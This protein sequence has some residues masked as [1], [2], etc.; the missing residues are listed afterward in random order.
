ML[1][2]EAEKP[3]LHC[4]K[5]Y[6]TINNEYC[7]QHFRSLPG[8]W[9]RSECRRT[10]GNLSFSVCECHQLSSFVVLSSNQDFP[11]MGLQD[12]RKN[13]NLH[14]NVARGGMILCVVFLFTALAAIL[15][16]RLAESDLICAKCQRYVIN[17]QLDYYYDLLFL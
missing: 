14:A 9:W 7:T 13:A 10:S 4:S 6:I 12:K 11:L 17:I 15:H 3:E 2:E 1:P 16:F 8:F 5:V